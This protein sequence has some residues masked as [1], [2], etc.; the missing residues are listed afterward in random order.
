MSGHLFL[1][2]PLFLT[3][4][5]ILE[6]KVLSCVGTIYVL[7]S[8]LQFIK[9]GILD[10]SWSSLEPHLFLHLSIDHVVPCL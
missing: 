8:V 9:Y 6:L 1:K 3:I 5:L 7:H 4:T 10:L 2:V